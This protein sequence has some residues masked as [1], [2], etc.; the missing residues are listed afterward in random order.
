MTDV[1]MPSSSRFLH[2]SSKAVVFGHSSP[3]AGTGATMGDSLIKNQ[4]TAVSPWSPSMRMTRKRAASFNTPEV[5]NARMDPSLTTIHGL[6][7]PS[8]DALPIGVHP[9][10]TGRDLICLCVPA[11]KIPRPRNGKWISCSLYRYRSAGTGSDWAP[12]GVLFLR[13]ALHCVHFPHP[14]LPNCLLAV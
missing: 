10:E 9:N 3:T 13:C 5:N 2:S 1:F 12:I 8:S 7:T 4:G 11:P 6:P 14:S